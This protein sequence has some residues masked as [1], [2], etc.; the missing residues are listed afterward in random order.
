VRWLA[1]TL[2]GSKDTTTE[3]DYKFVRRHAEEYHRVDRPTSRF[4]VEVSP[5]EYENRQTEPDFT[6]AFPTPSTPYQGVLDTAGGESARKEIPTTLADA[7]ALLARRRSVATAGAWGDLV[8]AFGGKRLG[9]ERSAGGPERTR[10]NDKC[11]ALGGRDRVRTAFAG[12]Y[13]NGHREGAVITA[14][15]DPGRYDSVADAAENLTHDVD[16]LRRWL[17]R[18]PGVTVIEP[19]NRGVPHAHV[20]LF[21]ELEELPTAHDLH[22]YW[23]THRERA[24]QIHVAPLRAR[25]PAET[26]VSAWEWA[27]GPPDRADGCA[28]VTYLTAGS[29]ALANVTDLSAEDVLT[30]AKAYRSRSDTPLDAS[31][32]GKI[33]AAVGTEADAPAEAVRQAAWYWATGLPTAT[34]PSPALKGETTAV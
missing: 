16:R 4:A 6:W 15:T 19:T 24:Q 17:D 14:T 8:G 18:P 28:P 31:R 34:T 26:G 25:G 11:R 13:D 10:F 7:E 23:H 21:T 32:A 30:V 29:H 9:E 12:A 5:G 20:A 22:G 3:A 27:E 2:F 33:D 1:R